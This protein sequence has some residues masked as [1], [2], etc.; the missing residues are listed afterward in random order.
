MDECID[1]FDGAI[2]FSAPD[3]DQGYREFETDDADREKSILLCLTEY[4]DFQECHLR[5]TTYLARFEKQ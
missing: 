2:I 3:A 5:C 4:F 1:S